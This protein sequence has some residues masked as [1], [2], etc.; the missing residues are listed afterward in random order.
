MIRTNLQRLTAW[1]CLTVVFLT[2]LSPAQGFVFCIEQ[3]G[4]VQLE[5]RASG[6]ACGSCDDHQ[7]VGK[8]L[9][10][11]SPGIGTCSC[12]D[13]ALPGPIE[14]QK[15]RAQVRDVDTHA[16]PMPVIVTAVGRRDVRSSSI[17]PS[18]A[19]IPRPDGSLALIRTVVLR[20]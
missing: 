6:S 13:F 9:P 16:W 8:E 7:V 19:A 1:L 11:D 20:V 4:C 3:D 14:Q 2:G 10:D 18:R 15:L 17:D 5:V 12:V